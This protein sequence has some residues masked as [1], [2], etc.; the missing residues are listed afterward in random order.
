M[1]RFA[2]LYSDTGGGHRTAAEAIEQGLRIA[3]GGAHTATV[4]NAIADLPYPFNFSEASYAT[5]IRTAGALHALSYHAIDGRR[6]MRLAGAI[7]SALDGRRLRA[8]ARACRADVLVS[9]QPHF[10]AF[11]PR[12]VRAIGRRIPYAHVVTDLSQVHRWHF[13]RE[14]DLCLVPTEEARDE[15]LRN[16]VP[17]GRIALTGFPIDPNFRADMGDRTAVRAALGL[18]D[19]RT[20]VLLMG[21]GEG[22]GA[23]VPTAAALARSDLPIQLLVVCGRNADAL[24]AIEALT[25]QADVRGF[26]YVDNVAELM[27]ASDVLI[28][29]AG[30]ATVCEALAAGLPIVLYGAVPGQETGN[31]DVLIARGAAAWCPGPDLVAAQIRAWVDDPQR[32]D[33]VRRAA[34]R[35]GRPDAALEA[36]R[37]L[38]ALSGVSGESM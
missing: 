18:R 22:M 23:L 27:G 24:R 37:A 2:L 15:A 13:P 7:A 25:G 35:L 14:L 3:F 31:R 29:K 33:H 1:A 30:A 17:A 5:A 20:T 19:D 36:A 12:A 10:N 6:R 8:F 9:C 38:A 4:I 28:T 16:G 34:A 26:G 32:R 11:V 21:G